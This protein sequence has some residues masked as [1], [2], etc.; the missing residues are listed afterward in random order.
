MSELY[1]PPEKQKE[2]DEFRKKIFAEIERIPEPEDSNLWPNIKSNQPYQELFENYRV[3]LAEILGRDA[4][5][6]D[7]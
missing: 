4:F 6:I 1:I 2:V 7:K 3:G 5:K